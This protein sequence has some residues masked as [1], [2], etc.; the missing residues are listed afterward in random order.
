MSEDKIKGL[1]RREGPGLNIEKPEFRSSKDQAFRSDLGTKAKVERHDLETE[2]SHR[3]AN[4]LRAIGGDAN[5][6][7]KTWTYCGSMAVHIYKTEVLGQVAFISQTSTL[8]GTN[9]QLA[10]QAVQ[11]LMGNAMEYYG[12]TRQKL[13]SGF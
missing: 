6:D 9:E 11:D 13:R 8:G 12:K 4:T 2:Q 3:L 10:A 5:P 1:K 7:G